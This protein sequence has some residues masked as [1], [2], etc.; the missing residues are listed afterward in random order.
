MAMIDLRDYEF[1]RVSGP[2]ALKFL[3]GQVTCDI[4]KLG[5]DNS[6]TGAICN[7]RGRVIADF[8]IVL[9]GEDCILRTQKGMSEVIKKSLAKYAIFSKVELTEEAGFCKVIGTMNAEDA[10]L[11][12]DI[13]GQVPADV[14]GSYVDSKAIVVRLPSNNSRLEV[15]VR[16]KE[17]FNE[18]QLHKD[19]TSLNDWK[20]EDI[21][22]G[23]VHINLPMSEEYTPQ[24]LN[25]DLSGVI[26]FSKGCYTGQEIIAR[27][28]Y[29]GN[30]KKRLF[31]LTGKNS[32]KDSSEVI[33]R[34]GDKETLAKVLAFSN[35]Y[36]EL[37]NSVLLAILNITSEQSS[38]S[39]STPSQKESTLNLVPL[40]SYINQ[41]SDDDIIE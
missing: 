25:Y 22:E 20:R 15:W 1:V 9:D 11:V 34:Y 6:L 33:Q 32:V 10:K 35:S 12:G 28:H 14:L 27:M 30:A 13:I 31:L 4:E 36:K 16:E 5:K 18:W 29:R 24:L 23:I 38:Y 26:D 39:L 8:L 19:E 41:V 21:M 3:Q 37:D 17:T 40:S 7:L 2:D